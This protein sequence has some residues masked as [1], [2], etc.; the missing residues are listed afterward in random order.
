[1][2]LARFVAEC[3]VALGDVGFEVGDLHFLL[4]DDADVGLHLG[5]DVVEQIAGAA[6]LKF[7]GHIVLGHIADRSDGAPEIADRFAAKEQPADHA[8]AQADQY[9]A[10]DCL[11]DHDDS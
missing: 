1:L 11:A 9:D 6:E 8:N 4:R 3:L 10:F 2:H 5:D 7:N